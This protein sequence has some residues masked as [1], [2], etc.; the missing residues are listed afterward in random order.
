MQRIQPRLRTGTTFSVEFQQ[1]KTVRTIKC[2]AD[3][4]SCNPKV[5]R[6]KLKKYPTTI[7]LTYG[8]KTGSLILLS[9]LALS[10]SCFLYGTV[11]ASWL[12]F[13]LACSF[14][15]SYM[16][17]PAHVGDYHCW[18]PKNIKQNL[19]VLHP[20]HFPQPPLLHHSLSS[21][22]SLILLIT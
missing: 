3:L 11:Q 21:L 7:H 20:S 18:R 2:D 5:Q 19:W 15:L 9:L 16:P 4:L 17:L 14:C 8:R 12:I 10:A 1:Q 13:Y 22:H 6:Y